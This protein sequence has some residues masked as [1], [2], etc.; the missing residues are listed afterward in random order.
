VEQLEEGATH[1]TPVWPIFGDLMAGLVGVFVLLLVWTLG[2]QLELSQ[3]LER[4][5]LK[6]E[7]EEQRRM[8]LEAALADPLASGRVTLDNGRIGISGSVLFD[9]NSARL[10]EDGRQLLQTL[11]A[12]LRFYLGEREEMLMVSGF[13]DDRPIQRGNRY[14]V[15]NW[16]LSAQRALT[17]TRAL[18]DA[19]MPPALVFAA[20]FGAQ[21]PIGPNQD[22]AGRMMNRRVEMAPVPRAAN[23]Q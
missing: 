11:V 16:E 22:E 10:Q 3:S 15:D 20:A 18:I 17:V 9:S 14:F 7:A 13:T 5:I 19:G 21:Q 1:D 2:I 23:P 12:P 6:R 8:A 4:E